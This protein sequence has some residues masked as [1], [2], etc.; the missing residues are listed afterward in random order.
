MNVKAIFELK[1]LCISFKT[2][3]SNLWKRTKT[4]TRN[5]FFWIRSSSQLQALL[6]LVFHLGKSRNT[7]SMLQFDKFSFSFSV[8]FFLFVKHFCCDPV[9]YLYLEQNAKIN[10]FYLQICYKLKLDRNIFSMDVASGGRRLYK[11]VWLWFVNDC[12]ILTISIEIFC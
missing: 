12:K 6:K 3:Y 11:F 7:F 5:A 1:K 8:F 9:R 10:L 4:C 2:Q